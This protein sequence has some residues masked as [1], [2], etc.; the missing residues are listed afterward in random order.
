MSEVK[1]IQLPRYLFEMI[2][3][4]MKSTL[5]LGTLACSNDRQLRS[6]KS[7]VK[8]TFKNEWK[9]L[10]EILV[11]FNVITRCVC[12]DDEFC[13]ICGGCRYLFQE[14]SKQSQEILDKLTE[15]IQK[16]IQEVQQLDIEEFFNGKTSQGTPK[17]AN[18]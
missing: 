5:D 15:G 12:E 13:E 4:L 10:A 6:Y 11:N 8:R 17:E 1:Y 7:T 14:V 9:D 3:R 2:N 18:L 16:A